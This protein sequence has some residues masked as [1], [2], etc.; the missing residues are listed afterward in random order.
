MKKEGM[1]SIEEAVREV[2][3]RKGVSRRV[4]RKMLAKNIVKG[5]LPIIKKPAPPLEVL[6]GDE[7]ADRMET[8][9]ETVLVSLGD[10]TVTFDFTPEE[11]MGELRSGRLLAGAS[12]TTIMAAEVNKLKGGQPT[13]DPFQFSV[14]G[15]HF[16]AWLDNPK[17]P[18]HL[19][20]KISAK[21][22]KQ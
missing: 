13:I 10:L 20:A 17:T 16:K 7:A 1:M 12:E 6:P 4:A 15:D 2:M 22:A 18:Q 19:V 9:P 5:E 21:R 11:L 3:R 8:E 14:R